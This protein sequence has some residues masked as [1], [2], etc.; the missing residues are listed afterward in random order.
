VLNRIP[1]LL[2]SIPAY[3]ID[4]FHSYS[5]IPE[6]SGLIGTIEASKQRR[7]TNGLGP[8]CVR[9]SV[10]QR[11]LLDFAEKSGVEIRWGHKLEKLE[12]H[13]DSVVATFANGAQETFSF[14]IGCDGLHS[15]TRQCLFG[16]VPADYTGLAQ[17]CTYVPNDLCG[18]IL[19]SLD[20]RVRT[21][22][23]ALQGKDHRVGSFW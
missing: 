13:E 4:E 15:S 6:D 7:E 18:L 12:Q 14:I 9:R 22:T 3:L 20:W 10:L 2:N 8:R 11:G 1:G 23:R 17:V 21:K 19:L 5:V 16:T